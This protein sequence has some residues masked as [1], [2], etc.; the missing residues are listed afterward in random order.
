MGG[1]AVL[2]FVVREKSGDANL[3][4]LDACIRA[5]ALSLS[6]EV[7]CDPKTRRL[8]KAIS[9]SAIDPPYDDAVL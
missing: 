8:R 2:H 9:L 6:S 7:E 4:V 3:L 5:P 1:K